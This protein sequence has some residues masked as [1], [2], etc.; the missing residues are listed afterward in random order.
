MKM[1]IIKQEYESPKLENILV[2]TEKGFASS[3]SGEDANKGI[4]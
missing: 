1:K 4:W 3:G 2:K